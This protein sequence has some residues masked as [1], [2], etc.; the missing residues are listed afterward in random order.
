MFW[1]ALQFVAA[2]SIGFLASE[3]GRTVYQNSSHSTTRRELMLA[4]RYRAMVLAAIIG[5]GPVMVTGLSSGG[6]SAALSILCLGAGLAVALL[7]TVGWLHLV[8]NHGQRDIESGE[9]ILVLAVLPIALLYVCGILWITLGILLV[10][11]AAGCGGLLV[12]RAR[13]RTR[14]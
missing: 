1:I 8:T 13:M 7:G 2:T 5:G 4:V 6:F 12:Y 9:I 14:V 11:A 10:V 3:A